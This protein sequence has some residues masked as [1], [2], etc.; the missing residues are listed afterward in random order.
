M[1]VHMQQDGMSHSKLFIVL[2]VMLVSLS[3]Q[4]LVGP[5]DTCKAGAPP[6]LYVG[7]GETYTHIQDALDNV[8]ADGFRIFVY[9]GTYTENLTINYSIDL[10]GEDS[11]ITSIDGNGRDTVVTVNADHVNISHFT[12]TNGGRTAKDSI[13]QV[14]QGN[15][16]ITDN[17]ISNGYTGIYLNHSNGNLVYDNIIRNNREAGL[18]LNQSND[19]VNITYNTILANDNGIYFYSSCGNK[20]YNNIIQF[21]RAN[22]IFLN[23]TCDGNYLKNNNC[24]YNNHSGIYVNDFSD[25]ATILHNQIFRNNDSGIKAENCSRS[26]IDNNNTIRKNNNYGVMIIGS[27][28]SIQHNSITGNLK[29]GMYCSTDDNNTIAKNTIGYNVFAGIRLYNSTNDLIY[30][31]D[32]FNNN[33]HGIYLDFFTVRNS[34]YNNYFHDNAMNAMDKSF[35]RN[36]WNTTKRAG[37]N[38]VGG[39]FVCGNYWDTFDE[40]A[41]GAIDSNDDGI[42][43]APYTIYAQNKD[44][45]AL[46]DVIKPTL[47]TPQV[48]P[49]SQSLGGY[50][51]I[52]VTVTDNTKVHQVHLQI[53]NPLGQ[54]SNIS[55]LQNKT[56]N[57]YFCRKQ[58]CIVGN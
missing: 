31:N 19:N 13:I 54:K 53:I 38:I 2:V 47:G 9:N 16:I 45:G 36:E 7:R 40:S 8:T 37:T 35:H 49:A 6:T 30:T 57:T 22:G 21:N 29:D 24:S 51:N 48:S 11:A 58:F 23:R 41:E 3:Y 1:Q 5:L 39:P 20:I 55:I 14:N 25:Y 52:S 12:I 44:S 32:I 33:Q 15:S 10:F 43:D 28:N 18:K 26:I 17:I 50:T 27:T 56:G 34:I 4:H 46:L 42:A